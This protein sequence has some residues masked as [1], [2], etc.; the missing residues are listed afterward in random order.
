MQ[1]WKNGLVDLV[2]QE[3]DP[4]LDPPG[5]ILCIQAR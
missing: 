2:E 3:E 5:T 1:E 4:D